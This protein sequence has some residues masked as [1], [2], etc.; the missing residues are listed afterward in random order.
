[1]QVRS[2]SKSGLRASLVGL[3]CNNLSG[4]LDLAASRK[5]VRRALDLGITLL[6]TADIYGNVRRHIGASELALGDS[7]AVSVHQR[8]RLHEVPR[9]EALSKAS[10]NR[11]YEFSSVAG[12]IS[13]DMQLRQAQGRT[14]LP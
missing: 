14:Q 8:P 3:D 13:P 5:V 11:P 12:T 7:T 2:V 10:I 4:R 9:L 6:Y 1:M